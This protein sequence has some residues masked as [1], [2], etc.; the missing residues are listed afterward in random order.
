MGKA[1]AATPSRPGRL[2][3]AGGSSC[4]VLLLHPLSIGAA[5]NVLR[6]L[7]VIEIPAHRFPDSGFKRFG[8]F[9]AEFSLYLRGVDRV[10]AVMSGTVF[11]ESD[12]LRIALAISARLELVQGGAQ[13]PY[14]LQVGFLVP[15]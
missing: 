11:D 6:P 1:H 12:L 2:F 4:G 14:H 10:P 7:P 15:A 13:C 3:R 8:G 5:D 9:P